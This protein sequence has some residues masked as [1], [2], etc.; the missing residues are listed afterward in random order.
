M[1]KLFLLLVLCSCL[2]YAQV[3]QIPSIFSDNMVLQQ[4]SQ[5]PFWGK[6]IPSTQVTIK[7]D[8]KAERTSPAD[9]AS[10]QPTMSDAFRLHSASTFQGL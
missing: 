2:S 9:R 10:N 8:W 6:G 4:K 5:V 3:V 7:A 1:K